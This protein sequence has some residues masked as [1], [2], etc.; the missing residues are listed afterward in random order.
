VAGR[1]ESL[2]FDGRTALVTGAGKGIGRACAT[3]LADCGASVVAISRTRTD[4]DDLAREIDQRGA[5]C[6]AIAL[7]V[8]DHAAVRASIERLE[9]VDI[10]VASAG[11]NVPEPFL[12]VQPQ[13]FDALVDLNLGAT[14]F[15][16]QAVAGRMVAGGRGGSIVLISSQMGHVGAPRRTVY[17]ATKH[18]VEGLAKAMAVELAPH[19]IRVNT[20]APT[21]LRTP[22]TEPMFA[23]GAFEEQARAAIPLGRIG[24]VDDVV[25][26]VLYLASDGAGLVTG[27]SIV[28]DGGYTAR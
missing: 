16:A 20:V 6:R 21:Y 18:A 4:L 11:R 25:G 23:D 19:G 5:T 10:L 3:A 12:D 17:C 14:F 28:V 26:A 1:S 24:E 9:T 27:T 8:T 22:M 13:T 15:T 7:D 2:R